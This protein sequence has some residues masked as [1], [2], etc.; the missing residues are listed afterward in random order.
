ML[1]KGFFKVL[2]AMLIVACNVFSQPPA[3]PLP[4]NDISAA[5]WVS[6]VKIGFNLEGFCWDNLHRYN[7]RPVALEDLIRSRPD[8]PF[9]TRH[10]V[11]IIRNA[12]FNAMRITVAWGKATDLEWNIREDYM[13]KVQ[14][15]IGWMLDNDMYVY[16]SFGNESSVAN[17]TA[18]GKA[19]WFA[20]YEKLWTQIADAFKNYDERLI[21][22]GMNEAYTDGLHIW[23][24]DVP[25][26]E[27]EAV[28]EANQLFVNTVRASGGNNDKRILVVRGYWGASAIHPMI[29]HF[30]I[31][32]DPANPAENKL[33]F[34]GQIYTDNAGTMLPLINAN[35][36]RF[37]KNGIPVLYAEF[38]NT[39]GLQLDRYGIPLHTEE[40]IAWAEQV[41]SNT[42]NLGSRLFFF[43]VYQRQILNLNKNEMINLEFIDALMRASSGDFKVTA[44][45][46]VQAYHAIWAR[47]G[48]IEVNW[49]SVE[50]ADSY[51]IYRFNNGNFEFIGNLPQS[52]AQKVV[53][54]D[55]SVRYFYRDEEL[56]KG[57]YHYKVSSV[58]S[59]VE[60]SRGRT[61]SATIGSTT[62]AAAMPKNLRLL[63]AREWG[64]EGVEIS[65]SSAAGAVSYNIYRSTNQRGGYELIET[66][67]IQSVI[68]DRPGPFNRGEVSYCFDLSRQIG[69]T[70]HYIITAVNAAGAETPSFD[71]SISI[72]LLAPTN[73]WAGDAGA[74]GQHGTIHV[75]W[76]PVAGATSYNVYRST[77]ANGTF[78]K[79]GESTQSA[80]T[81]TGTLYYYDDRELPNGT[82][83]YKVRAVNSIGESAQSE[84]TAG[85]AINIVIPAAPTNLW[86]GDA[87][88]WGQR[89]TIHVN[90]SPVSGA[91]S[92]NVYRSTTQN[93]NF[94]K[95]GESTQSAETENGTRYYY[96]DKGLSAGTY[97]YR[98]TAVNSAGESAPSNVASATTS[99]SGAVSIIDIEKSNKRHGIRFA[100]NPVSENA[101]ISVVLPAST[102]ST[103]SATEISVVIYDMTGNVVFECKGMA[104]CLTRS[105]SADKASRVLT[106]WDLR[107]SAGRFVANGTYLVVAEVKSAN[108][109]VYAYS[110]RLG[111]KR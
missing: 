100:V 86:A 110:A 44:P 99:G 46:D 50:N 32:D 73:V 29:E 53:Q 39:P 28:N 8:R 91:T 108:G 64:I 72:P 106:V 16:L 96:D 66:T 12:G 97:W 98:V 14:E 67:P 18:A 26:E 89:G 101:E 13:A 65:W 4:F 81:E 33:I 88:A 9:N 84:A 35:Y 78:E 94:V 51:N 15:V 80:E 71:L 57:T 55:G 79:I 38:G 31:P 77:S 10:E 107:N 105:S 30:R 2:A 75:N 41:V 5:E 68:D 69:G 92:Y 85:V 56:S 19:Q 60:S 59:G 25:V 47:E 24:A 111:V 6:N 52:S 23:A 20:I 7:E 40:A 1:K 11:E 90:W 34:A 109:K 45:I 76:S 62:P 3:E 22:E 58:V 48:D 61:A 21:F 36:E 93:G 87:G 49:L 70:Y 103:G 74:W 17:Y 82:Y 42:V 43:D 102:A 83:F 27:Y 104:C 63:D 54:Q 95:I 37:A